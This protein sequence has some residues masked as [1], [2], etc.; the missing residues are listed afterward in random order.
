MNT[1]HHTISGQAKKAGVIG[2]PVGHSKSP[3]LH[4]FWLNEYKIDGAYVPMAVKPDALAAALYA[5]PVL[6]FVGV[7]LTVPHKEAAMGLVDEISDVAK[8]IGAINT[9]FV[10]ADGRLQGTNTD[11]FGFMEKLLQNHAG[12]DATRGPCV[13]LGAG[14]AARAV[15]A[16]MI[17]AGCP[18]VIVVN[19]TLARG[20]ALAHHFGP[21]VKAVEWSKLNVAMS[22]AALLVNTTTL[23]MIG[24]PALELDL[25]PLSKTALVTDLVYSPL[26]TGLLAAAKRRANPTI[27]GLGMLLYQA[28]AGFEGWFGVKPAVTAAVRAHVLSPP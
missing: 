14:G 12:F 24:R 16:A 2:W 8:S 3:A 5:L 25:S 4:G 10:R 20:Q 13:V 28:Q 27:D 11:A 19:R 26:E 22:E 23:G 17:A 18:E 1:S 7:N 9:I 21:T 6:G 15:C